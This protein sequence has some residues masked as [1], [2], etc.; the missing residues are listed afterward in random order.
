[1]PHKKIAIWLGVLLWSAG[2]WAQ[3]AADYPARKGAVNDYAGKLEKAQVQ[4]L[5]GLLQRYEQQTSIDFA[6][7]VAD[8]LEGQPV[9]SYAMGLGES[10]HV[11]QAGQKNG[12]VLLWA[13]AERAYSLRIAA[14][15]SSELS[16]DDA[17][18]ITRQY[19]VPNFKRGEYYAG[20]KQTVLATM[21]HLGDKNWEQ[22]TRERGAMARLLEQQ[23]AAQEQA[24]A[25][26]RE[27]ARAREAEEKKKAVR[28]LG[29]FVLFFIVVVGLSVLIPGTFLRARHRRSKLAEL[30]EAGPQVEEYLR[31]A[32]KNA[33]EIQTLLD[34][35]AREMPEQDTSSLR[36]N[37]AGQAERIL[38][39]KVDF[40]C[41]NPAELSSYDEMARIRSSA[42]G[43]AELLAN[44]KQELARIK[45]A[46]AQSQAMM[47]ELAQK[48][49][50]VGEVRDSARVEQVNQLMDQSRQDY[51]RAQQNSSLSVLDWLLINQMLNHSQTQFQ[52][53][54]QYSQEAPYVSPRRD[55][56]DDDSSSR[57]SSIWNWGSNSSSSSSSWSSSSSSSSGDSSGF[58]SGSGSDGSY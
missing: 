25:R 48:K 17:R 39:I 52:Q 2:A 58:S 26:E 19:L 41:L 13:P 32:E 51:E 50:Q 33:P 4:E 7:V 43:E 10:W 22:R 9:G 38:K 45:T 16:D 53:A 47:A 24:Q 21:R 54:V 57:S 1:M 20:L 29:G 23:R 8:S 15:L 12:I 5:T 35:F 34:E 14:G 11:G 42:E 6:V 44:T 56:D 30:A 18:Q 28:D 55:Y 31:Q 27:Q 36:K 49:F 46:K 37:L 3:A 40:Q